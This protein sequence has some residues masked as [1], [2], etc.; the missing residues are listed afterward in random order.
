MMIVPTDN[1]NFDRDTQNGAL[2][3]KNSGELS[4]LK[5][6]R[7]RINKQDLDMKSLKE[8]IEDLKRMIMSSGSK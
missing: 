3:N 7:D 5:A 2:L 4:A 6:Q 8:Q 1:V